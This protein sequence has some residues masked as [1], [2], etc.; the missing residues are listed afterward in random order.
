VHKAFRKI[1]SEKDFLSSV[2]KAYQ[3]NFQKVKEELKNIHTKF[4]IKN[5]EYLKDISNPNWVRA[6]LLEEIEKILKDNNDNKEKK[7]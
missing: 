6:K 1:I 2:E 7:N 3:N 4:V 5:P